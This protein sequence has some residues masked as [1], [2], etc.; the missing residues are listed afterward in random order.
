MVT[1]T[2]LRV[3]GHLLRLGNLAIDCTAT[4]NEALREHGN[5]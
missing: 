2:I 4:E 5:G 1:P 3:A